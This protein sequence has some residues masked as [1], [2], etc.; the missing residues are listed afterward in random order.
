L[1]FFLQYVIGIRED[2]DTEGMADYRIL[3]Q[4]VHKA[5]E[6]L[7]SNSLGKFLTTEVL[8]KNKEQCR[9]M[10][11]LAF[12]EVYPEIATDT[13]MNLLFLEAATLMLKSYFD[14]M[15]TQVQEGHNIRVLASEL[16]MKRAIQIEIEGEPILVNLHGKADSIEEFDGHNRIVDFKT[17]KIELYD[18]GIDAL[19]G[20]ITEKS[21]PKAFQLLMYLWLSN[22]SYGDNISS[23]IISMKKISLG[24]IPLKIQGN[25]RISG[26]QLL[27][28][29]EL[30]KELLEEIFDPNQSFTLTEDIKPCEVCSFKNIC[31]R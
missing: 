28:F 16:E 12:G 5:V 24:Y 23:G 7:Y 17:G 22:H 9:E 25:D 13:G 21:K 4:A 8:D 18:V 27:D 29:E 1:Q 30:L 20:L 11:N 15:R 2:E 31:G 26:S 14:Y 10:M 6:N 19:A 3:G